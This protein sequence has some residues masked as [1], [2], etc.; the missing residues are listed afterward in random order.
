M[1]TITASL[2]YSNQYWS[3]ATITWSAAT[4][5]STW[6]DYGAGEE[7]SEAEYAGLSAAQV[8]RLAAAVETWDRIIATDL[9]QVADSAPGQIRVAM[10]DTDTQAGENVWGYAYSPPYQGLSSGLGYQG[11]VWI[12]YARTNS[13]F[14]SGSY[15]FMVLIHELGHAL[16]LKHSFEDGATLPADYDSIIYTIMSY[17]NGDQYVRWTIAPTGSGVQSVPTEV[18][19][20]TPMVFDIAALQSRY[21]ADPTTAAGDTTYSWSES[22]AWF[23]SIYDAGGVDTFDL[24]AHTRASIVDLTPG[25][26]SSIAYWSAADQAAWWTSQYAWAS[27][28]ISNTF[29]QN[30]YTWSNNVGIAYSTTIENVL[31]GSGS[32]TI[33]GNDA[34]NAV[35]GGAGDDSIAGWAGADYLRGDN[36][37]DVLTGGSEF[38]DINGNAGNDTAYGGKG[39]DWVVGGKDND[40]LYGELDNDVVYGNL[41]ADTTDGGVGDDTVRGGKDN[42]V[43]YGGDGDDWLSGDLGDDVISGGAGADVFHGFGEAAIDRVIDFSRAQGDRVQLDPGTA[44]TVSQSGADVVIA[45]TGGAQMVLVGVSLSS[46][47]GDWIFGA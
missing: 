46:L 21:G 29:T 43:L 25:G 37:N 17:E 10:T 9:V 27:S 2:L 5:S 33:T 41:G 36:G 31:A 14:A 24:S 18:F 45:M 34:A 44:Y 7:P 11:D 8:L 26:Y 20:S 39:G 42:D 4:A 3:G 32:D 35:Y 6:P 1:S 30:A 28:F 19:P 15:D 12:D 22:S 23:E 47:T 40:L 38:D 13:A 16:G